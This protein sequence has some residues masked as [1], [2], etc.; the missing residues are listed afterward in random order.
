M[1]EVR[2]AVRSFASRF[3]RAAGSEQHVA[4]PLGAWIVLALA[5][6]AVADDSL[7][8][9]LS[10]VL[11]MPIEDAT[12]AAAELLR[13]A[14]DVVA[15]A[16]AAWFAVST[17]ELTAWLDTLPG[18]VDVGAMPA[19]PDADAWAREHSLGLIEQ[20]PLDLSDVV[21]ALVNAIACKI[22]WA[23]PLASVT[24]DALPLPVAPGFAV[25]SLLR[26]PAPSG[27]HR[28]ML[29]TSEDGLLAVHAAWSTEHDMVVVSVI[30]DPAVPFDA[31]LA[32]AHRI[33]GE[34]ASR[35]AGAA[36][37]SLFD[38]PLGVGH[39]WTLAERS[40]PGTHDVESYET[41]LP[42][43]TA[44]SEHELLGYDLGFDVAGAALL[45][46]VDGDRAAAK[47]VA[48]A[49]YTREGFAAAAITTLAVR[50][51]AQRQRDS[52]RIRE[53]R[54]QFTRP[55]AVVAASAVRDEDDPW[56]GMPLFSAWITEAVEG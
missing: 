22:S 2:D 47:Q 21:L 35:R 45:R 9:R 42:A 13:T 32:H 41:T 1:S 56:A 30:A 8:D 25:A 3:H 5:A 24:S 33:A 53:A 50:A 17:D 39:S 10:T 15:L 6:P 12:R 26:A 20:F 38:V 46:L 16:T 36:Q 43:W 31:V 40:A 51:S 37:V 19:Q 49:H 4:S 18:E 34:I 14:P 29:V 52:V 23:H 27:D 54:V 48:V 11:G 7:R 28:T 44:D 55:H